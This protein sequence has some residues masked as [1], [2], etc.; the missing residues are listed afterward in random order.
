MFCPVSELLAQIKTRSEINLSV[1]SDGPFCR[2]E[3]ETLVNLF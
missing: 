3:L 2:D 1:K